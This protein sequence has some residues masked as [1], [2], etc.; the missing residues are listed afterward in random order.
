MVKEFEVYLVNLDPT[1]G[2]EIKKTRPCVVLS[3]A[4][5]NSVLGTVIIAPMTTTLR[6]YPS[7]LEIRFQSK[8]CEICLDQIRAV[9]E[10]R[11][12][13]NSLG[14]LKQEDIDEVKDTMVEM[15]KL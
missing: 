12:S 2:L 8:F 3:S 4:E 6:G 7:R 15:F 10:S 14:R 11:L 5:M 1:V 13:K 9:D